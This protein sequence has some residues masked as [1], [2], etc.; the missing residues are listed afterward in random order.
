MKIS[1]RDMLLKIDDYFV[2]CAAGDATARVQC[3]KKEYYLHDPIAVKWW[4]DR[5]LEP[6]ATINLYRQGTE[7]NEK[8][9]FFHGPGKGWVYSC[10][11][12]GV[13]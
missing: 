4:I 1:E 7:Q 8:Q 11:E 6:Y 5:G 12:Q 10:P 2:G 9:F 13:E 3:G